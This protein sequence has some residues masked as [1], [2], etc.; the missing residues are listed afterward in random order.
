MPPQKAA[1][2]DRQNTT[3]PDAPPPP[4]APIERY[5]PTSHR[6]KTG[7]APEQQKRHLSR[8]GVPGGRA[9]R[10]RESRRGRAAGLL[11]ARRQGTK[12]DAGPVWERLMKPLDK[13][14]D[15]L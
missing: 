11:S 5:A 2:G 4:K 15:L 8:Q 12:P 3:I 13:R 9:P 14:R 7:A 1:L 6:S 10:A